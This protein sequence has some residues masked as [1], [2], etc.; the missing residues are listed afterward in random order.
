MSIRLPF[1][2]THC[3]HAWCVISEFICDVTNTLLR[4]KYWDPRAISFQVKI[5]MPKPKLIPD[6]RPT[7]LAHTADVLVDPGTRR[8]SFYYTDDVATSGCYDKD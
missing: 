1:G 7:G 2:V 3:V 4:C 5:N 6:D 8:K